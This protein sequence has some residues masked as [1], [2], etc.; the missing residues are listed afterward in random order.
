MVSK[1][2]KQRVE[3]YATSWY[4]KMLL[5]KHFSTMNLEF[6]EIA[7]VEEV[8]EYKSYIGFV[9]VKSH[10]DLNEFIEVTVLFDK[11]GNVSI[12]CYP[13]IFN[14]MDT[15]GGKILLQKTY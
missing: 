3:R 11:R 12:Q 9:K 2:I 15:D 8:E 4:W 6:E 14:C 7:Q 10:S 13:I 5:E 1:F